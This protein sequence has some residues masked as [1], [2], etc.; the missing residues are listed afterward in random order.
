MATH[1]SILV[2][3][4]PW[5]EEPGGL[6]S[7]ASQR[8]GHKWL[9]MHAYPSCDASHGSP[10]KLSPC[11]SLCFYFACCVSV[12]PECSF[13]LCPYGFVSQSLSFLHCRWY[14]LLCLHHRSQLRIIR[15][16]VRI[17]LHRW[18]FFYS[19]TW[20]VVFL[21]S[22]EPKDDHGTHFCQ[23]NVK[24]RKARVTS[25]QQCSELAPDCPCSPCPVSVATE[26]TLKWSHHE[27]TSL[28]N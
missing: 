26:N 20:M 23:W 18:H 15:T 14:L 27:T 17:A 2:W 16:G 25:R 13:T 28:S 12:L 3:R 6:Q 9:S 10:G 11:S 5:T 24:E 21:H 22:P 1:S 4:I 8:V 7:L 19:S